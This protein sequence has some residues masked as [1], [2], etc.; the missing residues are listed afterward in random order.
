MVGENLGK[1]Y[2]SSL[3]W[4]VVSVSLEHDTPYSSFEV[5]LGIPSVSLS[6]DYKVFPCVVFESM[7]P[8]HWS[9]HSYV[10]EKSIWN[11]YWVGHL[12]LSILSVSA[13]PMSSPTYIIL[14]FTFKICY[15]FHVIDEGY[16][17]ALLWRV[18]FHRLQLVIWN[19]DLEIL[20]YLG[21]CMPQW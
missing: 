8:N 4:L 18:L 12:Q 1:G 5:G 2:V 14:C 11:L 21:T 15:S 9:C 20:W 16:I 3:Y 10:Q 17:K 7:L 19:Q 13:F 6:I